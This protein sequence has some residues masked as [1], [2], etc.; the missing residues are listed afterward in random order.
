[1]KLDNYKKVFQ[2]IKIVVFEI[3]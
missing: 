3:H 1:M 2:I